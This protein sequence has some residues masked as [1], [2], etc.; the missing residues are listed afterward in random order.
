MAESGLFCSI[1]ASIRSD[2]SFI[3]LERFF[4]E[5]EFSSDRNASFLS[6]LIT[7]QIQ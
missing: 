7:I 5:K 1:F 3:Y 6:F 4:C 2:T